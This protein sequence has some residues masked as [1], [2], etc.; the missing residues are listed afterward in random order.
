MS[1]PSLQGRVEEDESWKVD[2]WMTVPEA[3]HRCWKS[4]LKHVCE[5]KEGGELKIFRDRTV[6]CRW[7]LGD[8]TNKAKL[9]SYTFFSVTEKEQ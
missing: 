1:I 9:V 3:Q 2:V 4:N 5:E 7:N 8:Q 6:S